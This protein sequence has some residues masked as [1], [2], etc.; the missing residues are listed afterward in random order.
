MTLPSTNSASNAVRVSKN[1][2]Q[3]AGSTMT[4][5]FVVGFKGIVAF[6]KLADAGTTREK[7]AMGKVCGREREVETG[8]FEEVYRCW[9]QE[10]GR[11]RR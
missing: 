1:G 11:R 10:Y 5:M 7:W 6:S 8:A 2:R 9:N 3:M 4:V